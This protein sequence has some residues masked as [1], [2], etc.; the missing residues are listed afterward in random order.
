[1]DEAEY[2]GRISI[3]Y[4]GQIHAIGSPTELRKQYNKN[5][6]EDVFVLLVGNES[7]QTVN[8]ADKEGNSPY[9]A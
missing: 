5:T 9:S 4:A 6:V 3:M 8:S 7:D 2:C 1:M